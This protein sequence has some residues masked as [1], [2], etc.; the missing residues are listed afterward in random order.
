[1]ALRERTGAVCLASRPCGREGR[2]LPDPKED[3]LLGLS[4][5]EAA[6]AVVG[7]LSVLAVAA[8]RTTWSPH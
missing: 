7:L 2:G 1:M 3:S 6:E 5:A 8:G 4:G